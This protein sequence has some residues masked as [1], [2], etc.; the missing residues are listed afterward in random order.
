MATVPCL[1]T[2][3]VPP[4]ETPD[5]P[6]SEGSRATTC[7]LLRCP[8]FP[9]L[10]ICIWVTLSIFSSLGDQALMHPQGGHALKEAT[11]TGCCSHGFWAPG[12]PVGWGQGIGG[13]EGGVGVREG[14]LGC[15]H[16]PAVPSLVLCVRAVLGSLEGRLGPTALSLQRRGCCGS[17]ALG[18]QGLLPLACPLLQASWV[19]MGLTTFPWAW[20]S[21]PVWKVCLEL[22]V[23]ARLA[24]E[25]GVTEG[26]SPRDL[27]SS[28]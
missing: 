18:G 19:L 4:R 11:P 5:L 8:S 9:P 1:I 28:L 6:G 20:V 22:F 17:R 21:L 2:P 16:S 3:R 25:Q 14:F 10:L 23:P 15:P 7:L 27:G 26:R 13:V 24:E 12:T